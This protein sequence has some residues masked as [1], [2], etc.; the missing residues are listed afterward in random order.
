MKVMFL[1]SNFLFNGFIVTC[2]LHIKVMHVMHFV[3][4]RLLFAGTRL[5]QV[6][7]H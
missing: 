2:I 5:F 6:L 3:G 4:G 7:F 1:W